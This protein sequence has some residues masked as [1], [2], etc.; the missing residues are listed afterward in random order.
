MRVGFHDRSLNPGGALLRRRSGALAL[1][2]LAHALLMFAL[3][4]LAP[5]A[6]SGTTEVSPFVLLPDR[7]EKERTVAKAEP[8]PPKPVRRQPVRPPAPPPTP[9][10]EI[11]YK[12]DIIELTR[13]QFAAADISKMPKAAR[14]TTA[15]ASAANASD[16]T[17]SAQTG[18]HGERL[19]NADWQRQPS[20]AELAYYV[21]R[22]APRPSWAVIACRTAPGFRVTD[23]VELGESHPGYGLAASIVEAA[24][25]FRVLP[26]RLGGKAL[27]GEWVS[28]R[29]DFTTDKS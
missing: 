14:E 27:V 26:P 5:P 25:Q 2:I 28:I 21:P 12:L 13:D 23:C 18:P 20:Q 24:W 16:S 3:L 7:A 8:T 29:I 17:A 10:P 22:N 1:V 4:R 15:D 9:H 6:P 19:F 11:P